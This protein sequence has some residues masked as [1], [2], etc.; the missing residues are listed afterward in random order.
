MWFFCACAQDGKII[1]WIKLTPHTYVQLTATGETFGVYIYNTNFDI[2]PSN[3]HMLHIPI[4]SCITLCGWI[5]GKSIGIH[6]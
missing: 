4:Q 2:L 1:I 6:I 5:K 3:L